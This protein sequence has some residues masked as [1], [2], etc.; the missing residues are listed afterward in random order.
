MRELK[1]E[2]CE[3]GRVLVVPDFSELNQRPFIVSS[4]WG[5]VATGG[6]LAQKDKAGDER[7]ISFYA[8][9]H[10][11]HDRNYLQ[12][13]GEVKAVALNLKHYRPY[14]YADRFILRIDPTAVAGILKKFSLVDPIVSRWLVYIRLFD[15]DIERISGKENRVADELS[16]VMQK[17][18]RVIDDEFLADEPV[19]NSVEAEYAFLQ[20]VDEK[21]RWGKERESKN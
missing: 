17:G 21:G 3:G 8:K 15:F 9:T 20:W 12:F 16:R 11:K 2:F 14:V 5:P 1:A 18:R 6:Y 4:D 7:P 19:V 13:K 10:G